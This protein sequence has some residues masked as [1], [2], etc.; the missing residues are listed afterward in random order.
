MVCPTCKKDLINKRLGGAKKEDKGSVI[1]PTHPCLE[2]EISGTGWEV[3]MTR[4]DND[5]VYFRVFCKDEARVWY[6]LD[7]RCP[8]KKLNRIGI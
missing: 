3:K 8:K 7:I 1:S 6:K 4:Q 2:G 5:Y